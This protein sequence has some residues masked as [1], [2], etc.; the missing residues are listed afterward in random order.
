MAERALQTP[1]TSGRVL[2]FALAL[3]LIFVALISGYGAASI[4]VLLVMAVVLLSTTLPANFTRLLFMVAGLSV[5]VFL[6]DQTEWGQGGTILS[7]IVLALS[8]LVMV[9]RGVRPRLDD[10]RF[11]LI[12]SAA[13]I[14]L[15][16]TVLTWLGAYGWLFEQGRIL[17]SRFP[18]AS[19]GCKS[20]CST[21]PPP[22]CA[23]GRSRTIPRLPPPPSGSGT[24]RTCCAPAIW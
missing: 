22:R 23:P 2:A 9:N 18:A 24:R 4:L 19:W 6:R 13:L 17:C 3:V 16:L 20:S 12:A 10:P 15:L 5:L 11:V 1:G 8:V 7:L 14:V 21:T